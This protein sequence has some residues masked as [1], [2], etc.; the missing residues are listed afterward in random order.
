MRLTPEQI[1][2]IKQTASTVLG[3]DARVTLFGSRVDDTKKGGDI[4]LLFETSQRLDNRATTMGALYV[5][6][7]R[8]LGDRKIDILIKDP[9]T[10]PAPVLTIA[11]QTGIQL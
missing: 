3:A 1:E 7:I 4:D 10:P 8:K 2:A 5:A 9:A 6:L 11:K